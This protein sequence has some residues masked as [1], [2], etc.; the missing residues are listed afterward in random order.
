MKREK[1]FVSFL[2]KAFCEGKAWREHDH[3]P[4]E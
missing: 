2:A 3:R 4:D 1:L